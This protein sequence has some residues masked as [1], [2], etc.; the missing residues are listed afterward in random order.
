MK[1]VS[2]RVI[3]ANNYTAEKN[4]KHK[5]A[6]RKFPVKMMTPKKVWSFV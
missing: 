3:P 4:K 2:D 5:K 1:V 6:A